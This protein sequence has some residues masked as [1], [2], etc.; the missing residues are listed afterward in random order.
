MH[1]QQHVSR[2]TCFPF[3]A[4]KG[5]CYLV[6]MTF[7]N[8]GCSLISNFFL[9]TPRR[10]TRVIKSQGIWHGACRRCGRT[11][12]PSHRQRY[13][14]L[15]ATQSCNRKASR[16]RE[17]KGERKIGKQGQ[18]IRKLDNRDATDNSIGMRW[19]KFAAFFAVWLQ[20][21]TKREKYTK[22]NKSPAVSGEFGW[23]LRGTHEY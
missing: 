8:I 20:I 15:F 23:C 19:N 21:D 1:S 2:L 3:G 9:R 18:T 11:C 16:H 22:A 17:K 7:R 10:S 12:L 14:S 4:L 6:L 5:L 13:V